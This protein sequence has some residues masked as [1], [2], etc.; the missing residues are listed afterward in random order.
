MPN[1]LNKTAISLNIP[2]VR[3][4]GGMR[5][6][7]MPAFFRCWALAMACLLAP[8]CSI[9]LQAQTADTNRTVPVQPQPKFSF[10]VK[11]GL[12]VAQIFAA[13]SQ[14]FNH[15]GFAG[16]IKF[17][18][19]FADRF[20]FDPEVLYNMKGAA[21]NPNLAKGETESF[22]VDLD[23]VEIPLVF[24]FHFGKKAKFSFEFGP[25]IGFLVRQKAFVNGGE[26][27]TANGFNIYDLSLLFGL[28]YYLPRGFGLNFRYM[29]SI[30][31][32]QPSNGQFQGNINYV[33]IGQVNSVLNL[34]LNYRFNFSKKVI[35]ENG[36]IQGREFKEKPP[37][38]KKV[39]KQKGDVIDEEDN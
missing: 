15:F 22:S 21:R 33:S 31:P 27:N 25:S 28:N 32:I 35:L 13:G 11:A 39:K 7:C 5:L 12:N 8:L 38:Q 26:I 16:G 23:Y 9:R 18:Y 20:S 4:V 37:K 2:R 36:T 3:V 24:N 10:S 34:S 30:A 14:G 1:L 19:R 17:G 29:N 6:L